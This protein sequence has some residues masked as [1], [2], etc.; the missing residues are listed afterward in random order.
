MPAQGKHNLK[1][2]RKFN[3]EGTFMVHDNATI[4]TL[5]TRWPE[6]LQRYL[7]APNRPSQKDIAQFAI[8]F[9]YGGLFV[10]VDMQCLRPIAPLL[11][12]NT[13]L[14]V[15]QIHD[16]G[17]G[18]LAVV[19]TMNVFGAIAGH[20][21]VKN[22]MDRMSKLKYRRGRQTPLQYIKTNAACWHKAVLSGYD[23]YSPTP[24]SFFVYPASTFGLDNKSKYITSILKVHPDAYTVM[25]GTAGSWHS[26]FQKAY[27]RCVEFGNCNANAIKF[28][29]GVFVFLFI[30]FVIVALAF[31]LARPVPKIHYR[32]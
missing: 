5:L 17:L 31:L 16:N 1:S 14:T 24:L 29:Y 18:T 8:I 13:L 26:C 4:T 27:H 25:T 3:P 21:I 22:T 2:W 10:D 19:P 32:G 11:D 12:V 30:V 20:P 28:G 23:T 9:H 6:L 7:E 15:Q